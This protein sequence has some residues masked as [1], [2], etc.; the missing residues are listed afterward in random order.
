MAIRFGVDAVLE[1]DDLLDELAHRGC[2]GNLRKGLRC[3]LR[4]LARLPPGY[5]EPAAVVELDEPGVDQL[6]NRRRTA[7]IM[8]G[9]SRN[10]SSSRSVGTRERMIS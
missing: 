9:R 2:F 4:R 5:V 8:T 6:G 7:A 10:I 1:R 3:A